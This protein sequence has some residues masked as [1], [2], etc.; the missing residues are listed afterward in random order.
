[1]KLVLRI[2]FVLLVSCLLFPDSTSGQNTFRTA[3]NPMYWKNKMPYPGYWQQDVEYH[4][5][6]TIEENIDIVGGEEQLTYFNNSPDTLYFVYFNLYQNAFQPGSYLDDLQR[7]NGVEPRYGKYEKSKEGTLIDRITSDEE[8][9]RTQLDNTVMKVFLNKPLAPNKSME[10]DIRF[11]TFFD[12]GSTRRRMKKYKAYGFNHYNGCQWYPK[13]CVYDRKSGW[14]T[15]QHLNREFYGDFGSFHVELTFASNYVVEATGI[16]Q[17]EKE[18]LPDTLKA[19]LQIR[20]FKDKKWEEKPSVITPYKKG[21]TKTWKYHAD[22]VHDFAWTADPTYRI[23][24]TMW[25]GIRCVGICQESHASGWQNSADFCAK[26]IKCFSESVG[27]FEY[28]KMVVAD[29]QDGMEYPMITMDGG[30][31]PGY[32]SLLVHEV[33]HN[34]FYGMVGSNETYRAMMDE[35][36]TQFLTVWGMEHIDGDTALDPPSRNKYIRHFAEKGDTR[37]GRAY[38]GYLRDATLHTDEPLNTHS[39]GFNGALGQG[40]GYGMVYNKTS[41]M[42]Y[43]LQYVLG[44]SVF[45]AAMRHYVAQWKM[46]HPYPEDFRN[47]VIQF[48][49]VDLNWFFDEWMETTKTIDYK[50]SSVKK[51][52]TDP[53]LPVPHDIYAIKLKRKGRS[54]MPIDLRV[55]SKNGAI[56]DYHI[57]NTWYEKKLTQKQDQYTK[58][59]FQNPANDSILPKWYGWDKLKPT[60]TATLNIPGGIKNVI[61]DPSERLADI[62]DF[63]NRQHGNVEVRFDSRIY[64]P[65][66]WKKYRIWMRPDLWY[67]S[68]AGF[69]LGFNMKGSYMYVKHK[70]EFTIWLNTHL[71]QGGAYHYSDADL[72]KAGWINYSFSYSTPI[73]KLMKSTSVYFQSRWLDGF[74]LYKFG[75]V[76]TLPNNFA[77]D[78]HFKGF[79]RNRPYYKNYLVN[80]DEWSTYW[81]SPNMF[82]ASLNLT[83]TYNYANAKASGYITAH[84]RSATLSSSFNYNYLEITHIGRVSFWKLDLRTRI[85]G[86]F[87]MGNMV[88]S[89]SA[90]YFAGANE[91]DM[92]ENKYMR[93]A[94]FAPQQ[95]SGYG[96]DVNHLHYGG[97]LNLRGYTGYLITE[98]DKY[99]VPVPAYKGNSGFSVNGELDFNRIVPV[100]NQKLKDIFT[101]NTYLFGDLGA[102]AYSNSRGEQELSQVRFD[103]GA[104]LALTIKK[105]GFLQDIKPLTLRFDVPF[106]ISH[107][108]SVDPQ[109]VKFRWV[110]G[111][112]RAF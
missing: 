45:L 96:A 100:K 16:L 40:G 28:P 21:E 78:F 54:Q 81:D 74:E 9:L 58:P 59:E 73:N 87:G 64:P 52:W 104:G 23:M 56:Y 2:S 36:F 39:D 98:Y 11:R 93:A 60:Y 20:N 80:Q 6:A 99:G 1:M 17:N 108:P 35:G 75:L 76:K 66:S 95:W 85:Y 14:N 37:D 107:T 94:G 110:V 15:D 65:N 32:H 71:A 61:I 19:K 29:A 62:N 55:I 67:N 92:M 38:L 30:R 82:N 83:G 112:S 26:I 46:C 31:N 57:P 24:D 91:E 88:P 18:V 4:I 102:L 44:D 8:V 49:H 27:M 5:Q 69:Q 22:N 70:F 111:V 97:G 43:N 3:S 101:L 72:K 42:L 79:T 48:T 12:T 10:F 34:W 41:T 25:N 47:S 89:E 90:L 106:V 53:D 7:H 84:L 77:I 68:Y 13:I 109:Y 103:G 51:V 86:R 63:D 33:G 105:W 50:I